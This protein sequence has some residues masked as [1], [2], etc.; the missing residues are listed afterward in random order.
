[1]RSSSRSCWRMSSAAR[2]GVSSRSSGPARRP[3]YESCSRSSP[4][5]GAR[6]HRGRGRGE[7]FL[8]DAQHLLERAFGDRHQTAELEA[9]QLHVAGAAKGLKTEVREKVR[10]VDRLVRM[11]ALVLW[12]GSSRAVCEGIQS[13]CT[14]VTRIPKFQE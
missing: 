7:R 9:R 8:H 10:G 4:G 11:D 14:P 13:F 6:W 1:M 2:A 5:S 3:A 12:L